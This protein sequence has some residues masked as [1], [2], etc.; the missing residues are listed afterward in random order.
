MAI[1]GLVLEI[2]AEI[3]R[4]E[5]ADTSLLAPHLAEAGDGDRGVA[6]SWNG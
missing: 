3:A 2:L 5:A 6:A 1:E 4:S